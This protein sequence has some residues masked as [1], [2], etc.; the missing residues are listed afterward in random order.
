MKYKLLILIFTLL[1]S[2]CSGGNSEV[3][4]AGFFIGFL[5]GFVIYFS[6]ILSLFNDNIVIYESFNNG[7]WYD[8][9]YVLGVATLVSNYK[10]K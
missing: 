3:E 8:F 10:R 9:G 1:C 7:G 6:W 2:S 5:Q 4:P